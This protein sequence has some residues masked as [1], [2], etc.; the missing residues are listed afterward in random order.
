MVTTRRDGYSLGL[1]PLPVYVILWITVFPIPH[2]AEYRAGRTPFQSRNTDPGYTRHDRLTLT[3]FFVPGVVWDPFCGTGSILVSAAHFGAMTLGTDIDIRVIK[4]GKVDKKTNERVDVWSNFSDYGLPAPIGLLRMVRTSQLQIVHDC[5]P[6]QD[7]KTD[8]FFASLRTFTSTRSRLN[9]HTR[10][11]FFRAWLGIRRTG[12]ARADGKA[13][14]GNATTTDRYR[15]CRTSSK[16]TTSRAPC[17]IRFPSAWTVRVGSFPNPGT[18]TF[19]DWGARNY[20]VT[21]YIT[22]ALFGPITLSA[23]CPARLLHPIPQCMALVHS[24]LTFSVPNPRPDGQR[25]A[26]AG[27]GREA[28]FLHALR[29]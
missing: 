1:S 25:F 24:R 5:L 6:I 29:R 21:T 8:T 17:R 7:H 20:V 19:A 26:V 22:S 14:G 15:A 16:T 28:G 13:A 27:R 18:P 12:S 10:K 11:G 9:R 23:L 3:G 2:T 4:F